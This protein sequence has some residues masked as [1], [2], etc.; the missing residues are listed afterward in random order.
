M[1]QILD[2]RESQPSE[3]S[4]DFLVQPHHV[5]VLAHCRKKDIG[6]NYQDVRKDYLILSEKKARDREQK[7]SELK[8]HK[9][10]LISQR[11]CCSLDDPLLN[12]FSLPHNASHFC[13]IELKTQEDFE[14]FISQLEKKLE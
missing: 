13:K 2:P 7:I 6:R 11:I 14:S 12:L 3:I 9:K 10:H 4:Y 5:G 1:E 8:N